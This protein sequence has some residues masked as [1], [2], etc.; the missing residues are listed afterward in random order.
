M[1][2]VPIRTILNQLCWKNDPERLAIA[3]AVSNYLDTHDPEAVSL[4]IPFTNSYHLWHLAEMAT[5]SDDPDTPVLLDFLVLA[6]GA[7]TT[8]FPVVRSKHDYPTHP[9][10]SPAE[11]FIVAFLAHFDPFRNVESQH[12]TAS[13]CHYMLD[14][15][16]RFRVTPL[17]LAHC[18]MSGAAMRFRF[19]WTQSDDESRYFG[20]GLNVT[21]STDIPPATDANFNAL[22]H[23]VWDLSDADMLEFLDRQTEGPTCRY[24]TFAHRFGKLHGALAVLRPHLIDQFIAKATPPQIATLNWMMVVRATDRFDPQAIDYAKSA[25]NATESLRLL[26]LID[27]LRPGTCPAAALAKAFDPDA[28]PDES[29]LCYLRDHHPDKLPAYLSACMTGI[30]KM[31]DLTE[32]TLRTTWR[33]IADRWNDEAKDAALKFATAPLIPTLNYSAGRSS[34]QGIALQGMLEAD[35]PPPGEDL[36]AFLSH[37]LEAIENAPLESRAKLDLREFLL[38]AIAEHHPQ[39]FIDEFW[40]LLRDKS[41]TLRQLAI[42]GLTKC[43]QD[44]ILQPAL[45]LLDAKKADLRASTADLLGKIA[46]SS[47]IAPLIAALES[48]SSDGVR[49]AIHQAL[50]SCGGSLPQETFDLNAFLARHAKGLKLPAAVWLDIAKLPPL[51]STDESTLL[52]AAITLLI[53]KQSKH[54]EIAAATDILPLLA[55]IDR[56]KSAPFAAALVEGF[57]NSDQAASDRWALTLGGLLGDNR[58]ITMLL[59]RI[60]GWCENSRHKLAEYA[61][62]AISLLP[63][64]EPLMVLDT[65]ASRYRS[66]FKNVGKAC[67]AAFNAAATARGITADELGDMVVPDFGFDADGIRQFDWQG[68]GVSAELTPDFK[69]TWFDPESEKSWKSL[70]ATAP[71]DIKTEV[72]TLTKLLRETVKGQTARLEMTLVRQRRWPVARW[73]ELYENHPLLRSFASTLVWGVYDTTGTLLRTFRRYPN[74]LLADATGNLDELSETNI[75]I[76]MAHPLEL[77]QPAI[78]LWRAHFLRMKVKQPFP[79]IDRPVERMDP[80]HANRKSITLTEG[81]KL[82]VGTFKSRAEK[83]GWTRGS[84]VDAG[85]ISSYY[86][87]YPGAGIEAIIPT[88]NFWV[89]IDPMD[90]IE[91]EPAYFATADTV[92]RGSYTYDEPA[93]DDP[94]VLRFDQVPPVVFSETLADL[95]AITESKA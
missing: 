9:N 33:T 62:Q 69:L 25:T 67:A 43:P 16:A 91:L 42:K 26:V 14:A 6:M 24:G 54:K 30:A 8:A 45:D 89:G 65:L 36:R 71:D 82:N 94:R 63:G 27:T 46:D 32:H 17:R 70:P 29:G 48:E 88:N 12:R 83:R 58:I 34:L 3:D 11:D 22:D 20:C 73:R 49:A 15:A 7:S 44:Q 57:L 84:V 56:E 52:E 92:E 35:T 76:G 37:V 66:K 47:S 78:D 90:Q 55:H 19:G 95:K 2:P 18:I 4:L 53:A 5:S 81:K 13:I 80:L 21:F 51:H 87:L 23:I 72:K 93:P 86:K 64:D 85:G 1:N 59:P 40:K 68:G 74:G 61:A 39:P 31:A 77:D 41:K 75:D 79:Q 60:Q 28:L 50:Q 38:I 10:Q